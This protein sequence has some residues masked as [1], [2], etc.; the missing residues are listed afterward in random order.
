M[1]VEGKLAGFFRRRGYTLVELMAVVAIVGI[2]AALATYGVQKYLSATKIAEAKQTVGAITRSAVA[3]YERETARPEILI[4]GQVAAQPLRQLCESSIWVPDAVGKVKGR[5]YQ[6]RTANGADFN[7]GDTLTG[8]KCLKFGLTQPHYYQYHY[9]DGDGLV[10]QFER[11]GQ[12]GVNGVD[13]VLQTQVWN[14]GQ[15]AE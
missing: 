3:A 11:G 1:R 13:L 12:I 4:P 10:S 8:W 5:K 6:P 9:K 15:E 14:N 2:L 7:T